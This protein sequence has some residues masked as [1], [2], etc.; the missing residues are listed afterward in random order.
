MPLSTPSEVIMILRI[1]HP[2]GL[3][4]NSMETN[5]SFFFFEKL[6][7][8]QLAKKSSAYYDPEGSS[9]CSQQSAT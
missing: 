6:I 5:P 1:L 8:T 3:T 4:L 9:P 2:H 7:V